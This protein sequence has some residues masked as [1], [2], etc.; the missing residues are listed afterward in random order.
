MQKLKLEV[1]VPEN[2]SEGVVECVREAA[3][4]DQIAKGKIFVVDL[5]KLR[6]IRTGEMENEAL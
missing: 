2:L 1:A 3:N 5:E 6:R 4:N